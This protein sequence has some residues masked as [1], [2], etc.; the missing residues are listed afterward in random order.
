MSDNTFWNVL[1]LIV[2][3]YWGLKW[4]IGHYFNEKRKRF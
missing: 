1:V 4:L 3:A 2:V